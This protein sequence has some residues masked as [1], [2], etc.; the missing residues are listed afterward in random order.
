M[1]AS[2]TT[3]KE[4]TPKQPTRT[5]LYDALSLRIE[6]ADALTGLLAQRLSALNEQHDAPSELYALSL[7]AESVSDQ[8]QHILNNARALHVASGGAA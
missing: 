8:L 2:T 6:Q 1:K 7:V 3:Q 4:T 5:N